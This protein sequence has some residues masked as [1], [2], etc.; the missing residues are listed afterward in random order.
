VIEDKTLN[1]MKPIWSRSQSEITESEYADFYRHI[2]HD[3]SEPLKT[4]SLKAEGKIEY[5]SLLF[6][7]SK[8]PFDLFYQ[9]AENGLRLYAK[10]S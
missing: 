5:Q 4:I 7:P 6:I 8:A 10:E 2:S 3:W 9:S 1:S